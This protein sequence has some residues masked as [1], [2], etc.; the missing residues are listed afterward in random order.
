MP[1]SCP[2]HTSAGQTWAHKDSDE[3]APVH[4][5]IDMSMPKHGLSLKITDSMRVAS[6]LCYVLDELILLPASRCKNKHVFESARIVSR[7]W[8]ATASQSEMATLMVRAGGQL[9]QS[10][11]ICT[12]T[13]KDH[14][15]NQPVPL[16]QGLRPSCC[17]TQMASTLAEYRR[18]IWRCGTEL[19][20][21]LP[22]VGLP[23]PGAPNV[24]WMIQ[25]KYILVK[26]HSSLVT[27]RQQLWKK[28]LP[29][30]APSE[31]IRGAKKRKLQKNAN[32]KVLRKPNVC[33]KLE[34]PI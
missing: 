27:S 16:P 14:Q 4:V 25:L 21:F 28:T 3:K 19:P 22:C 34:G 13:V 18:L 12:S 23:Q 33:L 11:S 17:R 29:K 1:E 24:C 20:S 6:C 31:C 2:S 30:C 15:T 9:W 7:T 5:D 32:R 26:K 8:L 10:I